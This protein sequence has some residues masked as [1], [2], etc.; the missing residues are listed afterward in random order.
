M[1]QAGAKVNDSIRILV[2][3]PSVSQDLSFAQG[4]AGKTC[5][6]LAD[7]TERNLRFDVSDL[8]VAALHRRVDLPFQLAL[9]DGSW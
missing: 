5:T 6:S 2:L 7:S 1:K 8:S 4:I 9:L 3:V